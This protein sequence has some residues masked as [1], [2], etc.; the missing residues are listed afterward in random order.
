MG[1]DTKGKLKGRIPAEEI[2]NFIRS[3]YDPEAILS[4]TNKYYYDDKGKFSINYGNSDITTW[5]HTSIFFKE[6]SGDI[7]IL[8]CVYCDKNYYENLNYY[9]NLGLGEMVT[10]ETTSISLGYSGESIEI[11]QSIVSHFG[12]WVDENDCDDNPY[13]YIGCSPIDIKPVIHITRKQLYEK[14]GGVVIIDDL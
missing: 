10:S 4:D 12:G 7:R 3:T 5:E 13:Y 11:I 8:S 1:A 9:S 6:Y 2:L 14:F